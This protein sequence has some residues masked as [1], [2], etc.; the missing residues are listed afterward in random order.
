[1]PAVRSLAAALVPLR[2]YVRRAGQAL[3]D[4]LLP[5]PPPCPA[6]RRPKEP[7]E[8][9]I[10]PNC[11]ERMPLLVPPLC[12]RCGQPL[13]G[14]AAQAEL[15]RLCRQEGRFFA[16]ARAPAVYDGAVKDWIHRFKYGGERELGE[17]L[18]VLMGRFLERERVLWPLDAV[19]PVPLHPSRLQER[20]FNQ[21]EVLAKAVGAWVGRP[22]WTDVLQRARSTETQT[23]LPARARRDNVRGA[24]RSYRAQRIAGKRLLLVD[25]VLTS[26]AT[27]DEAARTLLKA[28]A[29]QVNVLCL[30]AGMLPEAW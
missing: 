29:A 19:V 20:G 13:R 10:C 23:K 6:C 3:L 1:M 5:E 27:A 9:G 11:L 8:P 15:C 7:D 12:R 16:F 25:D 21:A 18:G 24:F 2:P 22:V 30:A 26:G 4:L 17:A 14:E 28:G